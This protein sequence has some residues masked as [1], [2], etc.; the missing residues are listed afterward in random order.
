MDTILVFQHPDPFSS[1]LRL[2]GINAFAHT[3]GWN[4]QCLEEPF[5]AQTLARIRSFWHPVGT[6]LSPNDGQREY[7]ATLL[8][9]DS[10][11]LLDSFPQ[12]RLEDFAV[13]ITDSFAVTQMATRELLSTE[14]ASYGFVPWPHGYLWSESRR[15]NFSRIISQHGLPV[16]TFTFSNENLDVRQFQEELITWLRPLPKPCG[17]LAANDRVGENVLRACLVAGIKVPF[18]CRVIAV[19]DNASICEN[20]IPTMT[21]AGLDFRQSGYRA[22]QLLFDLI[23]GRAPDRPIVSVPPLGLT[24]RNSSRVFRAKDRHA[25]AATELI[26]VRACHGLQARDVLATFP[27]SRRM[28]EI[29]FR[30]ATGHSVLDEISAVRLE[31]AKRLLTNPY[32]RLDTVAEHCGYASDTTFRRVFKAATGLTL[33]E[34]QRQRPQE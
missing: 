17:I 25:L 28:A 32:Q 5:D 11:V 26:R 8:S 6:I 3:V 20:T 15:H 10:T 34:W 12:D 27:C 23:N 4:V 33:R 24:R 7:D 22:A 1:R 13:V 29:R 2:A 14:C 30:Q 9:P 31:R 21:S 18:D 19:D 16:Y